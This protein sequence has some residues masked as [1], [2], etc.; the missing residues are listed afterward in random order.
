MNPIVVVVVLFFSAF[1]SGLAVLFVKK[2][3][4]TFLKLVLSF[5]GAYLFGLTILHLIPHVYSG[6]GEGIHTIGL[7]VLGGFLFQLF[8]EY[9][10]QG[11]EHGHVHIEKGRTAAFPLAV[12]LSLCLHGFLEGMPIVAEQQMQLVFGIAV[13]HIPA[14]FALGS[15]LL[16][17]NVPRSTLIVCIALF[18]V[19]TPA[20]FLVS[21][22]ISDHAVGNLSLYFDK[23][24]AVV[25]GI[26]LHVSTTI[27]FE[28][29]SPD[30]HTFN[31]KKILAIVIGILLSL[32]GML[33]GGHHHDHDHHDH[34][35]RRHSHDHAP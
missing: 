34:D 16:M 35:H 4:S 1:I 14:A 12:L 23:M 13:H 27:L 19:M 24:M 21:K 8:L 26:F 15:L 18:A 25:I 9:F 6:T 2:D 20:G 28:S 3:S 17:A 5:S 11:V 7:Y 22:G 32:G 33:F 31:K 30:H 29:G 10:S